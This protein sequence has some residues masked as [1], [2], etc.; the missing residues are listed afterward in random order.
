MPVPI[1]MYQLVKHYDQAGVN[2]YLSYRFKGEM[3]SKAQQLRS[4]YS[5]ARY[6]A[7]WLG[8]WMSCDP[9]T[10]DGFNLYAYVQ[11]NPITYLDPDCKRSVKATFFGGLRAL[12][13]IVQLGAAVLFATPEGSNATNGWSVRIKVQNSGKKLNR[14]LNK[15]H[16]GI[17]HRYF[18]KNN[19]R[20]NA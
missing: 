1:V 10:E 17:L 7:P 14:Y 15:I 3:L 18:L 6:Y 11:N 4:D 20:R 16:M 8:R 13:G 2:A 12:G 5:G 9:S 19:N